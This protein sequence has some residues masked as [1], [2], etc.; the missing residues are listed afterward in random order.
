VVAERGMVLLIQEGREDLVPAV[1]RGLEEQTVT[2]GSKRSNTAVQEALAGRPVMALDTGADPRLKN[3]HS[4]S[5][6]QI[7]SLVCIPLKSSDRVLGVLYIDSRLRGALFKDDDLRFLDAFAA[8]AGMAL[9]S[10]QLYDRL[11][12][13]NSQL[14]RQARERAKYEDLIGRSHVMQKTYSLLDRAAESPF[15]ALLLGETGTGKEL[16]ARAIHR[17]GP[18]RKA[19]FLAANCAAFSESLL[20]SEL[21]GHVR[22]AFTGADSDRRGV[23][24][25]AHGGILFLD[26][27]GGMSPGLQAKLLRVLQDGHYRP[28][29]ASKIKRSD[30]RLLAATHEDLGRMVAE[31]RFREDLYYRLNVIR[32]HL[33]PLRDRREDIPLLVDHFVRRAIGHGSMTPPELDTSA[34]QSLTQYDWPGNVRELEHTVQRLVLMARDRQIDGALVRQLLPDRP[35]V[36]RTSQKEFPSLRQVEAL[37]L[38]RTLEQCAWNRGEAAR[39]LGVG[40]ATVYRKMREYNLQQPTAPKASSPRTPQNPV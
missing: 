11:R 34:L 6:Y 13:E 37:H 26:E 38:R 5:L 23:F 20:E 10:A 3:L 16:A 25:L 21:F 8:Q 12:Q 19:P 31:G 17:R 4:I 2:E 7:Q 22:G 29:G 14:N 33:P 9:D 35:A 18:R 39:R 40:R 28:L 36:E 30:V 32:I 1:I 27:I 15:P 24:D